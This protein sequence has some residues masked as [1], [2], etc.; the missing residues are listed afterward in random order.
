M[1]LLGIN[2]PQQPSFAD[3][4][5]GIDAVTSHLAGKSIINAINLPHMR[6]ANSQAAL[7][8]LLSIDAAA[9]L[10]FPELLPLTM[11][12]Q[13]TLSLVFGNTAGSA[14]AYANYGL[15]LCSGLGD[16]ETGYQF[17]QLA[18]HVLE[19]LET[20]EIYAR[21]SF[22]VNFFIKHWKEPLNQTLK[23]LQEA[24]AI[25]L[26]TGDLIHA[27][28]AAEKY[29]SNAYF[30][31]YN[32]THL[33]DEM[34]MYAEKMM[35]LKQN[36]ALCTHQ[37]HWQSVL[38]LI[39]EASDPCCLIGQAC[40][41]ILILPVHQ[42]NNTRTALYYIYFNK[43]LLCYLFSDYSQA[44]YNAE[45]AEQYLDGGSGQFIYALFYFYDSLSQLAIYPNSSQSKQN[46]I[47]VRVA[48]N[49]NK[50]YNWADHAPMNFQQKYELVEA[51]R[52]RVL[53]KKSE[54][55]EC[56]DKAI[57]I[58]KES[59]FIQEEA[60]ANELAAKFYL[61][62]G[63][64]KIA[65]SYMMKAYNCY[66]R[67]GAKSKTEELEKHYPQLNSNS[68]LATL[69]FAAIF[70]ASQALSSEIHLDK[71]LTTLLNTVIATAG[72][73]KCVLMLLWDSSLRAEAVNQL[74][75]TVRIF[76]G[77]PVDDSTD[78]PIS[79]IY[80][81]KRTLK[82]VVIDEA[83]KEASL[84]GDSYIIQ[85]QPRSLL[86][87]PLLNQGK[88][89]G[90][91]YLENHQ[92]AG[93]FTKERVKILS[94]LCCQAAISLENARLYEQLKNYSHDLEIKV[95]ERTAELEK[96]NQELYWIATLDG[97]TLLANRRHFDSYLQEQWQ[98]LLLSKQPLG[99]LLCDIDY[100][101]RYNDYY[102]HQAGDEC[103]KKVAQLLSQLAKR[104]EDLVAR[105]GGEEFAIILP[106]TNDFG[107]RKVAKRIILGMQ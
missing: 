2:F 77:I 36:V 21:T 60:L 51:E 47:L 103:L 18:L 24:Y 72:A 31:G 92:T 80:K 25:G 23:S 38:N 45:L 53:S 82:T 26:E 40:N 88:L 19:K 41:E 75:Q 106:N 9:Y 89:I 33:A 50:M 43:L 13:V 105:Y 76:Q 46:K 55:I 35:Q 1:T 66:T 74:G 81:V 7:Q 44:V 83:A 73:S 49:Q 56:Y 101:K 48:E 71:L 104:P 32:L 64:E 39:G 57:K 63:K 86:C 4:Q 84:L 100:F 93:V 98:R 99:L 8:I 6:D 11:C 28:I 22:I 5:A 107:A 95:A 14:K 58:A 3:W 52:Y 94:L 27:A 12:K 30:A 15:L 97:L 59:E 102:G 42:Q 37:I 79:L 16:L 87:S 96:V 10:S 54:A 91:L 67:W 20:K 85:Q 29:C 62:W 61:D 90:I 70:K 65:Q 34:K 69:D 78:I 68:T 17:G